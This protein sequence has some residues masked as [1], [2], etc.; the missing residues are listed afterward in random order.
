MGLGV[1]GID[2]DSW[3]GTSDK[4]ERSDLDLAAKWN[5]DVSHWRALWKRLEVAQ[6]PMLYP[7]QQLI[8]LFLSGEGM[9]LA[10]LTAFLELLPLAAIC[11]CGYH[12]V[13]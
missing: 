9:R 1:A 2:A 4:K 11:S 13:A 10:L 3:K 7:V 6:A 5:E 12:T 8:T